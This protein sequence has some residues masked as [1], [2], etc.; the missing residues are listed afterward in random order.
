MPLKFIVTDRSGIEAGVLVKSAYI[1]ISIHDTYSPP[2]RVKKQSGLRGLLQ[3]AFDDAEPTTSTELAGTFTLM[4]AE[5]AEK[6]WNFVHEQKDQVGAV[7]VHCEAGV[8][9]SPAV[10]AGLCKGLGGYDR[11]FFRRYQPNMHVYRLMLDEARKR[12]AE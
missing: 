6:I 5:Q 7:V 8:S 3:L 10:A 2:A 4:T 1:V 12:A 9:R 11:Q